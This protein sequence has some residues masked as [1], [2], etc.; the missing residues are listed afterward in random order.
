[1]PVSLD[2][3]AAASAGAAAHG[4]DAD[5]AQALLQANPCALAL[6]DARGLLQWCNAALHRG[7]DDWFGTPLASRLGLDA[8]DA[9]L[10]QTALHEGCEGE[11]P[12]MLCRHDASAP[13][14]QRP[15]VTLLPD[16]RR[17]ISL[18]P[19]YVPQPQEAE[20]RRLAELLDVAQELGKLG[21]WA[22]DV[23]TL[24][25]RW[26]RHMHRFWGRVVGPETPD[27]AQ[28]AQALV[29]EDRDA[30]EQ[31]FRTSIRQAGRY[32]QRYRVRGP[33]GVVRHVQSHW[34]VK[35]GAD[36]RP[37]RA[38]GIV[39]DATEAWNMART[40]GE[41][42]EKLSLAVDLA[43]LAIWSNDVRS[44]RI[45]LSDTAFDILGMA[46]RPAGLNR[47]ELIALVHPD[48]RP[49]LAAAFEAAL[50]GV[51][52][53]DLE[54][55]FRHSN[56]SW[57]H[58]MTRRVLRR[59]ADGAPL[60]VVGV[61][62]D[63]TERV[64]AS[65][66]QAELM[67]QFELTARTAGIGYWS[68]EAETG[69]ARWSEQI[70]LLHG[71]ALDQPAPRMPEWVQR[72][73]HPDERDHVRQRFIDWL[74]SGQPNLEMEFRILR[75]DG[76]VRHVLTHSRLEGPRGRQELFG[77]ALD[78]TERR[79]SEAALREASERA[80]LATRGAGLGTWEMDLR[81]DQAYWDEQMWRLRGRTPGTATPRIEERLAMLHPDD[82]L[83]NPRELRQAIA[84]DR[85]VN[86]EFRVCWPDGQV[87]WLASRSVTLRDAQGQP[88]R[89]IGVNWDIT[90]ARMAQSAREEKAIA[91][92]ES[93]AKSQF[94]SR[95]SHELRTPLNAVLGF[96][97]LLLMD[98]ERVSAAT[99]KRRL[100]QIHTA[101][102]HLLALIDD[103]LDLSS[104]EGG[105]LRIS[106]TPVSLTPLVAETMTLVEQQARQMKLRLRNEVQP[107]VVLADA[108]RLRQVVL[109][110]L[111]NAVKYNRE[112][113]SVTV[114]AEVEGPSA[115]LRVS[116][117]G[118]GMSEAQLAHAFEPFNRLGLEHEGI[119]GTG[120]GLSIVKALVG[121]MGGTVQVSST[122]GEGSV[123]EVR[124]P[125]AAQSVSATAARGEG[126][127]AP[128]ARR[129]PGQNRRVLYIEDNAVN[130]LIVK[131]LVALRPD[132]SM[133]TAHCG[134]AGVE[135]AAT[136]GPELILV[137][138]Q[139]P[140]ID[141]YEV[142]HRLRA[143]P[144]TAHIC[145]V[146]VSANAQPED[147]QRAR[148][149]G[150]A[151]YWTKPLDFQRFMQG[152]DAYFGP[153]A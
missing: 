55:R 3:K 106:A 49:Q 104:M 76:G 129:D 50:Q 128:P 141:G 146:A 24:Q 140:D 36:G 44:S 137:D 72:F 48:D 57:R 16:G 85:V 153:L 84:D 134:L 60:A 67:R 10:L 144:A 61:G 117:T 28:A 142:L 87:R 123:F 31:A 112:G 120:I 94:L 88:L 147:M 34:V 90:D 145:C 42:E 69:V 127:A 1:M 83:S 118:R 135:Q 32:S 136:L 39:M 37:E 4:L 119:E 20:V 27:F 95:M 149:A 6:T 29:D 110:M 23:H 126:A 81:D 21:V 25:G 9:S 68:V 63:L 53:V 2:P 150:F 132:L 109:N 138:M 40:F 77:V 56:G 35:N 139:L 102:R 22:R 62:L 73:G 91:Q 19:V 80:A 152:L 143:S 131:E 100:E 93:Q 59:D 113:G 5:T 13:M 58:L 71:L 45:Y 11:L 70:Y 7:Q 75:S 151:D 26:E 92:R 66:E 15:R 41:T 97:Q 86:T 14:W 82:R 64:L 98:G 125:G 30:L 103:V 124:L 54:I 122:A 51:K 38:L 130:L 33:D 111:T 52:P 101:G 18:L 116:D 46:P 108:T 96:A 121:R 107:V 114:Q 74:K 99:R 105:E 65:R 133:H 17:S 89:R 79:L 115:V 43:H 148:R 78:V 12:D 47:D 8:A